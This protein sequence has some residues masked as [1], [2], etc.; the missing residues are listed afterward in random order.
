MKPYQI[1]LGTI[2]MKEAENEWVYRPY[3]NSSKK[4]RI[5]E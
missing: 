2:E 5:L 3:M 4:R 1:R